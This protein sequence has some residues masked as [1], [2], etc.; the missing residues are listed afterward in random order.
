MSGMTE[1][2][3]QGAPSGVPVTSRTTSRDVLTQNCP[4]K[5]S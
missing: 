5:V 1:E 2:A 4:K 3:E